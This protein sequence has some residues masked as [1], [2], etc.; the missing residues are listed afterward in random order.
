MSSSIHETSAVVIVAAGSS[1]RMQGRDKLWTPLAG[2]ITLARTID[3]FESSPLVKTIVVVT[4]AERIAETQALCSQERWS[5]ILAVVPGGARR[6][7]SVCQGLDALAQQAPG[8]RWVMIHDAARPFVTPEILERGLASA[9]ASLAAVAAVPVKDTIKVVQAGQ[10]ISTPDRSQLW[11]IQTPQVFSFELIHQVHHL[12]LAQ[13]D[14][15]DDA[16]LIERAGQPVAVF[17][18]SYTNIKIT[19]Q[20]DLFFAEALLKG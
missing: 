1:R 14:A 16:T 5:K 13:E 8:C 9:Q 12:P 15:T 20:E 10:I 19:T 18:G 11:A 6:Q 7:D 3:V 4:N 2:R 17:P